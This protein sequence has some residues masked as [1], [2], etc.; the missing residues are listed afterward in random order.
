MSIAGLCVVKR[1]VLVAWL[2][3]WAHPLKEHP[4][5]MEYDPHVL[6][7]VPVVSPLAVLPPSA[8][9][10]APPRALA[11]EEQIAQCAKCGRLGWREEMGRSDNGEEYACARGCPITPPPAATPRR[12]RCCTIS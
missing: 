7:T 10:S 12:R 2:F 11:L 9:P 8:P 1:V 5:A 4:M 6:S 3:L